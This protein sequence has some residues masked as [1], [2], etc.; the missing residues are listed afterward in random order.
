MSGEYDPQFQLLQI[1]TCT[2]KFILRMTINHEENI[3]LMSRVFLGLVNLSLAK[4][5]GTI[6][7]ISVGDSVWN[8]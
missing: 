6:C 5:Q 1:Q 8:L 3:E 2:S 4:R 7:W